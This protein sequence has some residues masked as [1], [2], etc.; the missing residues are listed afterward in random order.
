MDDILFCLSDINKLK[1]FTDD[2][3]HTK[4]ENDSTLLHWCCAFGNID[5]L[6][7]LLSK[8]FSLDDQTLTG[9]YPIH[10]AVAFGN[11][12]VIKYLLS[13]YTYLLSV[14]SYGGKTLLN[15]AM[16]YKQNDI[17]N[18]IKIYEETNNR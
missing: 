11:L 14:Q 12:E 6:I 10:E 17:I 7:Y 5:T 13:N 2:Q 18:Y 4:F 1:E 15:E 9:F 3:L 16:K 8:G